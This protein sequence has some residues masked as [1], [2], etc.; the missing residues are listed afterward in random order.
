MAVAARVADNQPTPNFIS[1]MSRTRE[2]LQRL[3]R[4]IS[5]EYEVNLMGGYGIS[6]IDRKHSSHPNHQIH[7]PI[8]KIDNFRKRNDGIRR[9]KRGKSAHCSQRISYIYVS[10]HTK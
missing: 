5:D 3:L 10:C 2:A 6:R 9:T 8:R 4:G 7:K 1:V